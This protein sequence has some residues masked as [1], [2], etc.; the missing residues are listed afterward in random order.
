MEELDWKKKLK[1]ISITAAFAFL[2][3]I[4][5]T[6]VFNMTRVTEKDLK[7]YNQGLQYLRQNDYENAFFNFSNVSKTSA[8][9]EIALLR[10]AMSAD[11]IDDSVTASKKY[12]MFIEKYPES[13]FIQKAYYSL[14]QNYFKAKEYNKAEKT[15]NEIRKNFK[16]TEYTKASNYFLGVIAKEEIK[17]ND[18]EKDILKKKEKAKAYFVQYLQDAPDGRYGLDC[19]K[20]IAA[21]NIPIQ[22]KEF[23]FIGQTYYKNG[24]YQ[25]AYNNLN[26]SPMPFAWGYLSI[27]YTKRGEYQKARELFETNYIKYAKNLDSKDLN[28]VIENYASLSPEGMKAGWYKALEIAENAKAP[29]EDFILYRL[30][31]YVSGEE[32]NSLYRQIFTKFS[33]GQYAADAVANLFW[34]AYQRQDY[35]EARLL[36]NIHIRDYQ[37]TIS[38]PKI[39]FWMAKLD[40]KQGNKNEAKGLYQ[41]I[42]QKYPDSYYAY[43]A[44]KALGYSKSD[45]KTKS[46]HRLPEKTAYIEFPYKY[47]N[48]TD[49]NIKIVD[50]ILKLNDFKL[51]QEIDENNKAL[52]SWI[53]YKEGEYGTSSVLAR[54][55]IEEL[56]EKPDFDDSIYKLAYQLH[57]QDIINDTAKEYRL[58]PYLITSIIREESYF[59]KKAQSAAGATG[60]MQLMPSTASYIANKKGLAYNGINSLLNPNTNINLGCAYLSY[61]K[62]SLHDD[63]MLVVASYNGGPNAVQTWKDNLNYKNFDEFIENIPYQETQDYIKKVFRSYWVYLNVY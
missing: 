19:I 18:N 62:K 56:S 42:M 32:Q 44:N 14:A 52:L 7:A 45:W 61:V 3:L 30:T 10:Q 60:L 34:N 4:V 36:G 54:D 49:D 53:K 27:I 9:Y 59:N 35:S 38:A 8:I 20:E 11:K 31:K 33:E 29:G 57:Y 22:P 2:I 40:A 12:R 48:V 15:F 39:L 55:F 47:A 28:N 16:D 26:L 24:I 41:K 37:N 63:D 13:I 58:D 51:I 21:L 25:N 46:S 5:L 6:N 50:T 17:E 23:F 1:F 43:R